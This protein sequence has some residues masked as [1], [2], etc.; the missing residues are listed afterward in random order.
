MNKASKKR[1]SS[2]RKEFERKLAMLNCKR[3]IGL[4][5]SADLLL[6]IYY[7][8]CRGE[9]ELPYWYNAM[10]IV[11]F[12]MELVMA[13]LLVYIVRNAQGMMSVA[14]RAYY[15]VTLAIFSPVC[16]ADYKISSSIVLYVLVMGFAIFVPV[17]LRGELNVYTLLM[18]AV[19]V[20]YCVF[21]SSGGTRTIAETVTI[22]V[23]SMVAGRYA[24]ERFRSYERI[25]TG[26]RMKNILSTQD[27]L[28]GLTN[29][30]G[31]ISTAGVMW[32][33][34]VRNSSIVGAIFLDIDYFKNYNDTFGHDE[35]DECLKKIADAIADCTNMETDTV[36]RV[37]G[38][39]FFVLVQGVEKDDLI[40][41]ALQIRSAIARLKLEQEYMGT[42]KYVTASIGV[43]YAYPENGTSFK[44]LY[45]NSVD[46]MYKAK[47]NG[48]NC[49]VCDGCVYGR[50]R[51]G[52]GTAI[53][54]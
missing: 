4:A 18:A 12:T 42:S 24:Q 14:Y 49:I 29:K 47:E 48:R 21:A 10:L 26:S 39:A 37:G 9:Q 20:V 41:L 5:I 43:A 2:D 8:F 15:I 53:G 45:E 30:S 19:I 27:S 52:I 13:V 3:G 22:G 32:Q 1:K 11:V 6:V 16:I 35:G 36:A 25:N 50:M 44:S 23:L 54:N 51:N 33:F 28:T 31:L 40:A 17:L 7:F 46:A 34:C 38:E